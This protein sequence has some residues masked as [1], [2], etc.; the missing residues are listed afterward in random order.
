MPKGTFPT[1]GVL[2]GLGGLT[3]SSTGAAMGAVVGLLIDGSASYTSMSSAFGAAAG[4]PFM[5]YKSYPSGRSAAIGTTICAAVGV[6]LGVVLGILIGSAISLCPD[7][8]DDPPV[9]L[10]NAT[11]PELDDYGVDGGGCTAAVKVHNPFAFNTTMTTAQAYSVTFGSVTCG[12]F[13]ATLGALAGAAV[14]AS[15]VAS[16]KTTPPPEEIAAESVVLTV[17]S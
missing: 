15:L 3:G 10:P 4:A 5:A 12:A 14:A 11:E 2:Y 16:K 17:P 13:G 1:P 8:Y 7:G 6:A 9:F